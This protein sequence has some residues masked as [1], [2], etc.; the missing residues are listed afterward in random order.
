MFR[1]WCYLT[2][3]AGTDDLVVAKRWLRRHM[4]TCPRGHLRG[5]VVAWGRVE[6]P[7]LSDVFWVPMHPGDVPTGHKVVG[8]ANSASSAAT[9]SDPVLVAAR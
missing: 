3:L 8:P 1:L 4:R 9:A 7:G 5:Q 2:V 6:I